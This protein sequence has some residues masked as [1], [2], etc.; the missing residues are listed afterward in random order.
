MLKELFKTIKIN[1][2]NIEF[3]IWTPFNTFII[4]FF[5][6]QKDVLPEE[7]SYENWYIKKG[8]KNDFYKT[9]ETFLYERNFE[10]FNKLFEKKGF[11]Y[12]YSCVLKSN[13][14]SSV[15][16]EKFDYKKNMFE[17]F[18]KKYKTMGFFKRKV[19]NIFFGNINFLKNKKLLWK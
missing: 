2:N 11:F 15:Y 3:W 13:L 18:E 7:F 14:A 1:K 5:L 12:C 9:Q 10:K 17:V 8:S 16:Y 6:K 4:N 19:F